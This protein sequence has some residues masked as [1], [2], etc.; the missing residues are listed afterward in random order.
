MAAC[1]LFMGEDDPSEHARQCLDFAIRVL[2][3]LD[4]TNIKLNVSLQIRIWVNAEGPI[5]AGVLGT[6]NRVFD[7]IG[8]TIN[9]A[10]RLEHKAEPGHILIS[11]K[12]YDLVNMLGYDIVPIGKVFLKGKGDMQAYLI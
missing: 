10:S 12:N 9:V 4:D 2:D 11:E 7:I 5:I 8:N 6:E 1:W 3:I